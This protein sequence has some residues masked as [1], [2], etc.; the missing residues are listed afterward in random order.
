MSDQTPPDV[1][2]PAPAYVAPPTKRKPR[3]LATGAVA[4]LAVAAGAFGISVLSASDGA[5]TPEGAV[6]AM[7]DA[8]DHEDV[9]GVLE[10]LDPNERD[11]LRPAIEETGEQAKR[12]EVASKDLDLHKVRGIDLRVE[13]L[14]MTTTELGD[15][16]V[17]VDLTGGTVSS[18]SDLERLPFGSTITDVLAADEREDGGDLDRTD[19]GTIDL[20]GVRLVAVRRDGGWHVS[21][22]YSIAEQVRR[23]ADP[24]PEVPD[25]GNGIAAK[26]AASPE[27]AVR[28][29]LDAAVHLD[30]RRL[31]ELSPPGEMAVLHDYGPA[32]VAAAEDAKQGAFEAPEVKDLELQVAD[33]PDGTKVVSPTSYSVSFGGDE[34][35]S[36][37][38]RC[39]TYTY[40]YDDDYAS[41]IED[42]GTIPVDDGPQTETQKVCKGD[43]GADVGSFLSLPFAQP[44]GDLRVVTEQHDGQWFV[45]PTRSIIESTVGTLKGLD[46]DQVRR[47]VRWWSGDWWAAEPAGFWK[48]CGVDQPASDASSADGEAAYEKCYEQL[49]DDYDGPRYG[50]GFD[51]G[52][53]SEEGPSEVPG[54]EC[55]TVEDEAAAT[56]CFE[57]LYESGQISASELADFRCQSVYADIPDDASDREWTAAEDAYDACVLQ[58]EADLRAGGGGTTATSVAPPVTMAPAST[59][60]TTAPRTTTSS[61]PAA[62]ATSSTSTTAPG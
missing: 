22:L 59:T 51:D 24:Q 55:W 40:S 25:F 37:D 23:D 20:D 43:V 57:G 34:A 29:A 30:V 42:E 1:A 19:S 11:I 46:A 15:G 12:V 58:Q 7:F 13:G 48:A 28:E 9:I 38:G 16:Y 26:G 56:S 45:S 5:K 14:A 33:G 4:V 61:T 62:P 39:T 60:S 41:D 21:A 31:I 32:L 50:Y 44:S 18:A 6:H 36:F 2:I 35:W 54:E 3:W 27:A 10:A 47:T 53:G 49:P 8:I 52:F 17:A